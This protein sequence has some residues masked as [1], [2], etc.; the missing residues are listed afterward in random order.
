[1]EPLTL[2]SPPLRSYPRTIHGWYPSSVEGPGSAE[3]RWRGFG[4]IRT[5]SDYDL[6]L[7]EPEPCSWSRNLENEEPRINYILNKTI[8]DISSL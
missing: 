4:L 1:M 6:D 8:L 5:I 7:G 3:R 2:H